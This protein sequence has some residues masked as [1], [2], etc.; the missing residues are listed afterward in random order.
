MQLKF[1]ENSNIF[2]N[3]LKFRIGIIIIKNTFINMKYAKMH[4]RK[5]KQLI[6]IVLLLKIK[7]R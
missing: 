2:T 3:V 7:H 5:F 4:I 1:N 6:T